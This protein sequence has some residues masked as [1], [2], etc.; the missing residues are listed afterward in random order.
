MMTSYEREVVRVTI[1]LLRAKLAE[2]P[3]HLTTALDV[4]IHASNLYLDADEALSTTEPTP[5]TR[6]VPYNPVPVSDRPR[7]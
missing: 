4:L 2:R 7:T 5:S 1:R 6:G 3:E